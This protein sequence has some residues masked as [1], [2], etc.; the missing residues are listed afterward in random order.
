M[1]ARSSGIFPRKGA[2]VDAQTI[3]P[4]SAP[5]E[6]PNLRHSDTV[7]FLA[8]FSADATGSVVVREVGGATLVTLTAPSGGGRALVERSGWE[9]GQVHGDVT[10]IERVNTGLTA[11][12]AQVSVF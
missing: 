3:I 7:T 9:I 4:T 2:H 10:S 1:A 5:L 12:T 11:G 8:F 6:V